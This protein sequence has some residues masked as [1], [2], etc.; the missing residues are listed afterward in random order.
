MAKPV[1]HYGKWRIRPI[2]EH[3]KRSSLIYDSYDD[4]YL[5]LRKREVE[6]E[7]INRGFRSPR[8]LNK[9]LGELCDYWLTKKVPL[10]RNG[11]ADVS[12]IN[13]HLK[14]TF[15]HLLVRG[16]GI[17]QTDE[18]QAARAHLDKKTV[19]NHLTLLISM[20]NL[21]VEM[22][23]LERCPKIKKPKIRLFS[24]DYRYLR[25]KE[26]VRRF[27]VAAQSEDEQVYILY[28]LATYTGLREGEIAALKKS[29]VDFEKRLIIVQNSFEGPT[30]AGDV[31]YVPILDPLL[32]ILKSWFLKCPG[33]LVFPNNA[34][35][36]HQESARI[37]QETLHRVLARAGFPK[38]QHKGKE[39]W[40]IRF[41]D[42]R[43]TFASHWV[44][45]SG[46][47]FKLQKILGHKSVTMTMR[48]AH[49]APDAYVVDYARLGGQSPSVI[50][51]NVI[52]FPGRQ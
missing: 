25:N 48:Y 30:K 50:R 26:E 9:T 45:N 19:A 37:F 4:A 13:R 27:L 12:I 38:V 28:A 14:P 16:I 24:E 46:D 43:H 34:G 39:R 20:L 51:T 21:A 41:H 35:N 31:R 5:E 11:A 6:V 49:L 32:P 17:A 42:L 15:G 36:M 3:G 1:K 7:E 44:M 8:V 33:T 23:W 18:Y 52:P 40:Y 29:S 22:N 2:D 47:I 10:K